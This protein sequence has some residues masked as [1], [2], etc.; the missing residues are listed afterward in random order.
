LYGAQ[1]HNYLLKEEGWSNMYG[2]HS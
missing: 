2:V 1:V